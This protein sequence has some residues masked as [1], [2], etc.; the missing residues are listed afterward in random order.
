MHDFHCCKITVTV[1]LRR[2]A[3]IFQGLSEIMGA[4]VVPRRL[5]KCLP[6]KKLVEIGRKR[7]GRSWM[8]D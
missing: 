4:V 6:R 1:L 3:A 2:F 8:V 5:P 7:E